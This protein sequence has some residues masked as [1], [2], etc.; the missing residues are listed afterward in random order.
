M[1]MGIQLRSFEYA[2]ERIQKNSKIAKLLI[3]K[4]GPLPNNQEY[5][6]E[7]ADVYHRGINEVGDFIQTSLRN[8]VTD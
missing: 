1:G 8:E 4:P 2:I 6:D 3:H 5:L 7:L